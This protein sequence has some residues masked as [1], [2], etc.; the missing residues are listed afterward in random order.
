MQVLGLSRRMEDSRD[1]K[2]AKTMQDCEIRAGDGS[3][4]KFDLG[5]FVVILNPE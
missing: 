3:V 1:T 4:L 5:L 2:E